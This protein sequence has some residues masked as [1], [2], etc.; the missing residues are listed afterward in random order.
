VSKV[1][2]FLWYDNQAEEAA[3][4]Y[5]SLI[6][7]SRI[8]DVQVMEN[9]DPNGMSVKVVTFELD[10]QQFQAMDAGP[11]FK[12]TEAVSIM[13]TCD[14]QAEVDRLW[15]A[16]TANGGEESMCGW[17]KDPYGL[18]WQIT[19]KAMEELTKSGTP[20]QANAVVQAMLQM[21]KMD[22]AK[23]RAAYDGAA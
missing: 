2:T 7:N 19:P 22:V 15:D 23:L 17:L 18:S 20:A 14:D 5:T 21:R 8:L 16:L 1:S 12:F 9:A 3:K 10:G 4:L 6:P 11:M 13:I